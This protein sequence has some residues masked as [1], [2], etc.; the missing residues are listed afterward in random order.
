MTVEQ[1]YQTLFGGALIIL[2]VLIGAMCIRSIIGPRSTDRIMSVNMLGTMTICSIAILSLILDEG[3]L[4]DVAL[5]YAMISFVAV[6]MMA[7]MFV[8]SKPK[9]PELDRVSDEGD[10]G[11]AEEKTRKAEGGGR[12]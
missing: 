6:L 1:A 3:Y 4:A 12:K 10:A 5:I 8:P 2:L 7:S 9:E 11:G